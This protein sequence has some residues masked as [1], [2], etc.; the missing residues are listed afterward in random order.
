MTGHARNR[1]GFL[2]LLVATSLVGC[3]LRPTFTTGYTVRNATQP[4]TTP[5][6]LAVKRFDEARPPRHYTTSG[7][8]FLTY[9]PLLPYVTL[10]FERLDESVNLLNED[11][12]TYHT[13]GMPEAPP[14]ETYTYPVS[15]P[16]AIADDLRASGFFASVDYV[17]AGDTSGYDYVLTGQVRASPLYNSATSYML[18]MAGVLLWFLPIPMQKTSSEVS[19]D[20]ELQNLR[21]GAVVWRDTLHSE[22]SR[23]ATMYNPA[24]VYGSAGAFSLNV[25]QLQSDVTAVDRMSLFQWHFES[26]RRAMEA[27]K[28]QLASA[29]ASQQ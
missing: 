15:I 22:A 7:R 17:D 10:S 24:I 18:G 27:A 9:I 23:M 3:Q 29:L 11:I 5:G 12:K 20:V 19:V 6:R 4:V 16:R 21:S 8:L 25:L 28:P 1:S 14:L 26:L 2:A 13:T